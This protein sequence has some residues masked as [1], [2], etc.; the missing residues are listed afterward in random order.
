MCKPDGFNVRGEKEKKKKGHK[1]NKKGRKQTHSSHKR[2]EKV[3]T[4]PSATRE[5]RREE[6]GSCPWKLPPPGWRTEF[7]TSESTPF[8]H[9]GLRML[10]GALC[11]DSVGANV[12]PVTLVSHWGLTIPDKQK[13]PTELQ[14]A[15]A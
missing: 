12:T 4:T 15:M 3:K 11:R 6:K 7:S 5:K 10:F 2:K 1:K 13:T 9:G 8:L 14:A